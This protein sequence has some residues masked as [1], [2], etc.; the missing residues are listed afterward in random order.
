MTPSQQKGIIMYRYQYPSLRRGSL[1]YF[2]L[3]FALLMLLAACGNNTSN[4]GSSTGSSSTSQSTSTSSSSSSYGTGGKY[5]NGGGNTTPTANTTASSIKTA[6]VTVNGKAET[7]LT[8]AAGMTLYYRTSDK[9]PTTVCSGGCASAWPPL[10]VTGSSVP[11]SAASLPGK[12]SVQTDAN[13]NQ[14][15]Y[16]GHPLYTYSGD[17]APGQTN[18]EGVA[19]I[20]FVVTSNLT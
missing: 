1:R 2:V 13:G 17:S 3:A 11:S 7:I 18:G 9:P 15:Q 16:N 5:G 6:T 10:L 4:S 12:L 14:V 8:N 20:W 19:G